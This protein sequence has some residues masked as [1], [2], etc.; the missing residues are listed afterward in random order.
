V[1]NELA[2]SRHLKDID[3]SEHPGEQLVRVPL[4]DFKI[5]GPYG[6]HQ[7]LLFKPL[8]ISFHEF[9][10][11]LRGCF[12]LDMLQYSLHYILAGLDFMHQVGII[13]TGM[14]Y[15]YGLLS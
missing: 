11:R 12:A 1:I 10:D 6:T 8:G 5:E 15:A 13:H 7:C 4:N 14:F 2:V 3:G 9:K